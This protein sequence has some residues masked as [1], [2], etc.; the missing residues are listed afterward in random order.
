MIL[1]VAVRGAREGGRARNAASES[2]NLALHDS[3][4]RGEARGEDGGEEGEVVV[5]VGRNCLRLLLVG[6]G[7]GEGEEGKDDKGEEGREDEGEEG[8]RF[9]LPLFRWPRARL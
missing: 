5:A 2:P 9:S 6:E 3:E 4:R 7:F 1:D 8:A